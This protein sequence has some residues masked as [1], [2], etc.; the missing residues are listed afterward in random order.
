MQSRLF[1]ARSSKYNSRGTVPS[2]FQR[3]PVADAGPESACL[4]EALPECTTTATI[5]LI[6]PI[7]PVP[8]APAGL[9]VHPPGDPAAS[10]GELPVMAPQ[11]TTTTRRVKVDASNDAM[12]AVEHGPRPIREQLVKSQPLA[13]HVQLAPAAPAVPSETLPVP[14]AVAGKIAVVAPGGPRPSPPSPPQSMSAVLFTFL[15]AFFNASSFTH[16]GAGSFGHVYRAMRR[17]PCEPVLG[18]EVGCGGVRGDNVATFAPP[19][20]AVALKVIKLAASDS[21]GAYACKEAE[22]L[23]D[24]GGHCNVVR[25]YRYWTFAGFLILELELITA[26]DSPRC[27]AHHGHGH[28]REPTTLPQ[29]QRYFSQLFVALEHLHANGIIHND[30]KPSNYLTRD[31]DFR[32]CRLVDFGLAHR[33]VGVSDMPAASNTRTQANNILANLQLV[34]N[35]QPVGEWL[36]GNGSGTGTSNGALPL[37]TVRYQETI[38][39]PSGHSPGTPGFRAA[40]KL[41]QITS[42]LQTPAVDIY[43]VGVML[44]QFVTNRRRFFMS[45]SKDTSLE[46]ISCV[47][48]TAAVQSIARCYG[49]K[50]TF[51]N[52]R[53]PV[54]LRSLVNALA[55]ADWVRIIPDELLNLAERCLDLNAFTRISAYDA[56]RHP[57]FAIA[58]PEQEHSQ[59]GMGPSIPVRATGAAKLPI[60]QRAAGQLVGTFELVDMTGKYKPFRRHYYSNR[61]GLDFIPWVRLLPVARAPFAYPYISSLTFD[62]ART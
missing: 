50:I 29:L 48:G 1:G 21:D 61:A 23:S 57:F 13:A 34:A 53:T 30:V 31:G 51:S 49:R 26:K 14:A 12:S 15:C 40:E 42:D 6:G 38:P 56:L 32:D 45:D 25:C 60:T 22:I 19:V 43:S 10:D 46:E 27:Q 7:F 28:A 41:M 58:Y 16:I 20:S 59:W 3:R 2:Q 39:F 17:S 44:L 35:G 5:P 11:A 47:F 8:A 36:P 62:R 4:L 24:V 55:D 54:A 9:H 33:H 18:D 37:A 52:E